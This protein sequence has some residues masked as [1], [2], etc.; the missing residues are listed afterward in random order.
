MPKSLSTT[1]TFYP[2]YCFSLSPTYNTWARLTAADVHAL[3]ERPGFEGQKLYFH[4]NHPIKWVRLVGVIVAFEILPT[5][6]IMILDDSSG[7]TIELTSIVHT[8]N[9]EAGAW[10]ENTAFRHD[11]LNVPWIVSERNEKRAKR[12]A[13]GLNRTHKSKHERRHKVNQAPLESRCNEAEKMKRKREEDMQERE[14]EKKKQ[15][16]DRRRREEEKRRQDE[17]RRAAAE[18]ANSTLPTTN[19]SSINALAAGAPK[20]TC[21][22]K[23]FGRNLNVRSC[24]E[25]LNS[26]ANLDVPRTFG[27]RGKGDWDIPLPFRFLSNDGL[28][29]VDLSLKAGTAFDTAIPTTMKLNA[30]AVLNICVKGSPNQGGVATNLGEN[31]ALSIRMT[32][33]RPNVQCEGPGTGPPPMTCR[34]ILDVLPVDGTQRKFGR[35]EDPEVQVVVPQKWTTVAQRCAVTL[36]TI[37]STDVSD[38]Y[39]L[40]A[41]AIAVEVMCV[42]AKGQGGVAIG[43]GKEGN[44]FIEIKDL[45]LHPPSV[46]SVLSLNTAAPDLS[47]S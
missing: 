24:T 44:L 31:G 45:R 28:C 16:G 34:R 33:Y 2:A 23:L 43:L 35:V 11:I 8:T 25:A 46:T 38:W 30:E 47:S 36:N 10:A 27:Q 9:E 5:L 15:D 41:A 4:L 20:Y 37:S 21:N 14:I 29:A 1:L 32:P 42:E 12:E 22:G 17:R 13:E 18:L 19:T 26:M 3:H 40:W 7:A 6:W 39:K